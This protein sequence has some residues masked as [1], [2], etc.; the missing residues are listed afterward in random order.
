MIHIAI[1]DDEDIYARKLSM[2]VRQYSQEHG[3]DFKV[4][5]FRD[6]DE[7]AEEYPGGFDIILMDIQMEFMNGM[8]AARGSGKG[9]RM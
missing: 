5:R 6:G 1:V 3:G 2:Y 4:T 7:I 8:E 9:T